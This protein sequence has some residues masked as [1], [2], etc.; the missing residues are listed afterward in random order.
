MY[1]LKSLHVQVPID[2]HIDGLL[3]QRPLV[4]SRKEP[5]RTCSHVQYQF[6]RIKKKLFSAKCKVYRT[7]KY[8]NTHSRAF[9]SNRMIVIGKSKKV[10]REKSKNQ[11]KTLSLAT[12]RQCID[13]K[14]FTPPPLFCFL[15]LCAEWLTNYTKKQ[16]ERTK[17]TDKQGE[18]NVDLICSA[19]HSMVSNAHV[20]ISQFEKK[21]QNFLVTALNSL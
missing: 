7:D 8:T 4:H 14:Y 16:G 21:K 12:G 6:P 5:Q 2:S 18:S 20:L 9:A 1:I 10:I 15:A 13:E 19:N 17:D 11:T 3:V